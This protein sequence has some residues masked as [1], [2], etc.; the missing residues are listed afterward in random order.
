MLLLLVVLAGCDTPGPGFRGVAPVRV[1]LGESDFDVR[2]KGLRAEAIRTNMQWAPR[3]AATAPQGVAAIEA[4]ASG[5]RVD[6]LTGDQA[7]MQARLDCGHGPPP[8][9]RFPRE[10]ECEAY[11]IDTG[12]GALDC[13]PYP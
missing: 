7:M 11:E 3:M 1:S 8:G 2:V 12:Y 9:P 10:W 5:C 13:R 4:A 6:T